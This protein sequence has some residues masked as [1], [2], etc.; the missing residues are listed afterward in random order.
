MT[1]GEKLFTLLVADLVYRFITGSNP[2]GKQFTQHQLQWSVEPI[3]GYLPT[4]PITGNWTWGDGSTTSQ[5][6]INV[7]TLS[8]LH[9]YLNK[10][11]FIP[12]MTVTD[13][14]GRVANLSGNQL[15]ILEMLDGL[16]LPTKVSGVFTNITYAQAPVASGGTKIT[17]THSFINGNEK[18]VNLRISTYLKHLASV[19]VTNLIALNFSIGANSAL[20]NKVQ[21]YTVF[22]LGKYDINSDYY[23][24]SATPL[25]KL[26]TVLK[27]G[28]NVV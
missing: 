18:S 9:K 11:V 4:L 24:T 1:L 21:T 10:G 7:S 5:P 27:G 15:T 14:A 25:R 13:S 17:I 20:V 22:D 28:Y 12:T 26:G 6:N 23:D 8:A 3:A 2:S 19:N 16:D